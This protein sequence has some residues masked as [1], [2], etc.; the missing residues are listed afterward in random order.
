LT[1]FPKSSVDSDESCCC[2]ILPTARWVV[3]SH[4]LKSGFNTRTSRPPATESTTKGLL[5]CIWAE[6]TRASLTS[7]L[8]RNEMP[9]S[10]ARS[11]RL[12]PVKVCAA[13]AGVSRSVAGDCNSAAT[14]RLPT[15]TM[16]SVA[17]L[18]AASMRSKCVS[19]PVRVGPRA[20]TA[21]NLRFGSN[22]AGGKLGKQQMMAA[23]RPQ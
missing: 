17:R 9:K 1:R 18:L 2:T 12:A 5:A 21:A 13:N 23:L 4:W 7:D 20:L 14:N 3:W 6:R 22:S 11:S 19:F 10:G 16:V 8:R 15:Y